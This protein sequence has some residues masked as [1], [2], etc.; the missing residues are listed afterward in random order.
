MEQKTYSQSYK[1]PEFNEQEIKG[2]E[3]LEEEELEPSYLTRLYTNNYFQRA[4]A[5]LYGFYE[6]KW[7][8]VVVDANGNLLTK[9]VETA[10]QK[11]DVISITAGDTESVAQ[12]FSFPSGINTTRVV[13]VYTKT[14][15]VLIRYIPY[16]D[17]VLEQKN[18]PANSFY[19]IDVAVKGFKVQNAVA[20]SNAVV[21]VT[22][23]Y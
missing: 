1:I 22:G 23:W 9:S 2:I 3:N 5:H 15:P 14:N 13:E 4:L 17:T 19:S 7:R 16:D 8:R 21:E 18:L 10:I 6:G 12:L 11:Y 20:G